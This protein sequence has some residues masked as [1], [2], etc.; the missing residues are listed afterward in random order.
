MAEKIEVQINGESQGFD[1]AAA[2]AAQQA[3]RL[4]T[5]LNNVA[6]SQSKAASAAAQA[7]GSTDQ[8]ANA[9]KGAADAAAKAARQNDKTKDSLDGIRTASTLAAAAIATAT[10]A[11]GLGAVK[12]A[13]KMEQ[14]EIAFTTMLGN[15]EQAK[16][17]LSDLQDFAQVTPFD[18]ESVTNGSRR[19]LA[20]G[21]SAEQII[22]VMTAVGDAAAGLGMQAEGIDRLTLAM[23]QM[24]AKGKVSAEE[25]RQFAEAG[26][27]GWKFISDMLE[28]TIPEAMKRGE[29]N[30]IS[31]AQ[32]LNAIVAGMNSKFGGMM[33]AQSHTIDG[34]W[35]N[36]M[37]GISR[38]SISVGKDIVESFDLHKKLAKAMDFFDEFRERVDNSGLRS[39]I[40]QSVPTEVVAAAFV[41]ID[42]AVVT[43]LIPAISKAITAFRALRKAMLATPIGLATIA[44]SE[45]ALGVYDKVQK[46]EQG[47]QERAD[48]LQGVFDAEGIEGYEEYVTKAAGV[49]EDWDKISSDNDPYAAIRDAAEHA[50]KLKAPPDFSNLGDYAADAGSGRKG[51]GRKKRDTSAQ[52]AKAYID[53]FDKMVQK[54]EAFKSLWDGITGTRNTMFDNAAEQVKKATESYNAARDARIKA[55]AEGNAKA[56]ELIAETEAQRLQ[57]LQQTEAKANEVFADSLL[58]RK[59][60]MQE[61]NN[62]MQTLAENNQAAIL[63]A[64]QGRLSAE[65]EMELEQA[66]ARQQQMI[67]EQELRQAYYDWQLESQESLLSFG[68][69]AAQTLKDGLAS[70]LAS[71]ITEGAKL[72]DVLKNLGKQILNMFIQWIVGRQLAA[73]FSKMANKMALAETKGI[74]AAS[75]AAWEPAA[76]LAEAAVPGSIA[77]GEGL[78]AAVAGRAA[79]IGADFVSSSSDSGGLGSDSFMAGG[80]DSAMGGLNTGGVGLGDSSFMRGGIS[81]IPGGIGGSVINVTSNNYGQINNGWDADQLLGGL[82]D[83]VLGA[84]RS[85]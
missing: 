39:A 35:S 60:A 4:E 50:R 23:G 79:G 48:L 45:V 44:A 69:E 80:L 1:A 41:A 82:N 59:N 34:M 36:L 63:A 32:G 24:A 43:T 33:E 68:L 78:A 51:S 67:E 2:R 20:M 81:S 54:A 84:L 3:A 61:Y 58:Q 25:I 17:M 83:S 11:M 55:E 22:P 6:S 72:G 7:A 27:P 12:A 56:A 77:R 30:Q 57:Y 37:D 66:L 52:E 18:L 19:L 85:S 73:V 75:A 29:Q 62:Q 15:A 47:G 71:I 64:F 49:V 65:Q 16:T 46:Y 76:A 28:I 5:A 21:F 40:I 14:L 31:A 26:V 70:G 53:L 9:Q 13:G 74:A 8:L 38:T 42:I 10:A